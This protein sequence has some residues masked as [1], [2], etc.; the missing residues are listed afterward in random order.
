MNLVEYLI[1]AAVWES[2]DRWPYG[3]VVRLDDPV[4]MAAGWVLDREAEFLFAK[5]R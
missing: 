5:G 1:I 2:I 4:V 3:V